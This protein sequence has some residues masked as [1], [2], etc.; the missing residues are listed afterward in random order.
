MSNHLQRPYEGNQTIKMA[1]LIST[2][3]ELDE[4][5]KYLGVTLV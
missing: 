5:C 4:N 1:Q 3:T 2:L